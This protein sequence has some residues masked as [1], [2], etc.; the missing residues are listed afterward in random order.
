MPDR[1]TLYEFAGGSSAMTALVEALH[2]RCL[3]DPVL[4]HAFIH[5]TNP[6]HLKNLADYF[7]EVFGGPALYSTSHGGH[8]AMLTLHASTGA[9]DEFTARFVTCF[10][11][12]VAD[13]G[14]PEDEE[15]RRVL[16]E[17]M[18]WAAYEVND[19]GP[20]GSIVPENL[21]FPHWSWDGR[22]P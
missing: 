14:L 18:M 11:Q 8:S 21:E 9:D 20:L 22:Q 6:D 1:A 10:D 12:A 7:T 19:Y 16:H 17:Y 13:A 4:N 2:E 5:A 15:F 3:A